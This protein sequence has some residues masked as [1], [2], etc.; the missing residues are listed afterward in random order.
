MT[1]WLVDIEKGISLGQGFPLH[2]CQTV[3]S[4]GNIRHNAPLGSACTPPSGYNINGQLLHRVRKRRVSTRGFSHSS[5]VIFSFLTF[6][7][8]NVYWLHLALGLS[9][10]PTTPPRG[11]WGAF[12]HPTLRR[13]FASCIFNPHWYL[14]RPDCPLKPHHQDD[15]RQG[16]Q[17]L[18]AAS[19][20]IPPP[21]QLS[22]DP[23]PAPGGRL[24]N[25]VT[26]LRL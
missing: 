10:T 3:Y 15:Y 1:Y 5:G 26:L 9:L 13:T 17:N 25:L 7:S 22:A 18:K 24:A 11:R 8:T 16:A 20:P 14:H 12:L 6:A 23:S 4:D 2:A 21:L 19:A